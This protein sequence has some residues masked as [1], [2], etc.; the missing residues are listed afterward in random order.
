MPH[1]L[2]EHYRLLFVTMLYIFST[3]GAVGIFI[4]MAKE[5]KNKN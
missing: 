4:S 5:W 2:P 3:V 1:P